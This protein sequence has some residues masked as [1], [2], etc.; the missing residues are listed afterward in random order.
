M[1]VSWVFFKV[2]LMKWTCYRPASED[3]LNKRLQP[4]TLQT[5]ACHARPGMNNEAC[6]VSSDACI[7]VCSPAVTVHLTIATRGQQRRG[8]ENDQMGRTTKTGGTASITS[9]TPGNPPT[10]S[11]NATY[12]NRGFTR[13]AWEKTANTLSAFGHVRHGDNYPY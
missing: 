13:S 10:N 6:Q 11:Y 2:H 12:G 9:C 3:M 5:L 8:A 7:N 4:I 1:W